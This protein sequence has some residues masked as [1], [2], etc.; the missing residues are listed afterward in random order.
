[1]SASSAPPATNTKTNVAKPAQRSYLTAN[2]TMNNLSFADA[3]HQSQRRKTIGV[4]CFWRSWK[5]V[6]RGVD[7]KRSSSFTSNLSHE[8]VGYRSSYALSGMLS[9]YLLQ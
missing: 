5:D 6:Y 9:V 2:F 3:W 1:M 4:R 8:N 7:S